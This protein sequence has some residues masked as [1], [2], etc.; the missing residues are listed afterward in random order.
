[1]RALYRVPTVLGPRS[2][3]RLLSLLALVAAACRGRSA[4]AAPRGSARDAPPRSARA[5]R[6]DAP[7]VLVEVL[8]PGAQVSLDGRPL[9]QGGRAVPAPPP[10]AH[11]LRVEAD[12]Y[13]PSVQA[14]P[15][16]SLAGARVGAALRPAGLEGVR[17]LDLDDPE[18]LAQAAAHLAGRGG[19]PNDAIAYAERAIQ[20]EPRTAL[21]HR[22]LGDARA[23]LGETSR[24]VSSWA[25]YLRLAPGA[26][27]AGAVAHRIE[28]ARGDVAVPAR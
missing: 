12:G 13:E 22:A 11:V 25:E 7:E 9:G 4:T 24:A 21:G 8:P 26:P 3:L 10:G 19:R 2:I 20:L 15:E 16:G 27:D 5:P 28:A 1:M 18:G 14:L 23:A 17:A 6:H